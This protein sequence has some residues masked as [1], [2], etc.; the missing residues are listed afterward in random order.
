MEPDLQLEFRVVVGSE[1]QFGVKV[2]VSSQACNLESV[3]Q[4]GVIDAVC[5]SA[6]LLS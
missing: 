1:L 5:V 4:F 6:V 2:P 3:L